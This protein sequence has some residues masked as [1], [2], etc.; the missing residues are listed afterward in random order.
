MQCNKFRPV[1]PQVRVNCQSARI[2]ISRGYMFEV[3]FLG[4][5]KIGVSENFKVERGDDPLAVG[6]Y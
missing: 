3:D 5:C 1:A 4:L 2:A 6:M